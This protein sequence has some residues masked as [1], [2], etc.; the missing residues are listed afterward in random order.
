ML[1]LTT[2][3]READG[4]GPIWKTRQR[5]TGWISQKGAMVAPAVQPRYRL[6]MVKTLGA[7]ALWVTLTVAAACSG[8]GETTVEEPPTPI[9]VPVTVEAGEGLVTFQAEVADSPQERQRGLMFRTSLGQREGMLFVF[10]VEQQ[11]SFWMRNTLISLD[12][13]FI[14]EDRTIL[15]VVH[16]AEPKTDTPRRVTG[17]SKYVL[18]VPGGTAEA[19]A[20]GPGQSVRFMAPAADR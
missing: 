1:S 20:I 17:L 18:E 8:A 6:S 9:R 5:A 19:L 7:G 2:A 10:P 4:F 13:I 14:R 16:R 11:L 15:G 12:M 3:N